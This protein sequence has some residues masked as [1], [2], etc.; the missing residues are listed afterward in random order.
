MFRTTTAEE[1]EAQEVDRNFKAKYEVDDE[2]KEKEEEKE[3][4]IP[5]VAVTT[6]EQQIVDSHSAEESQIRSRRSP[7]IHRCVSRLVRGRGG[8]SSWIVVGG[9]L[10]TGWYYNTRNVQGF[11]SLPSINDNIDP[12]SSSSSSN[13]KMIASSQKQVVGVV[14]KRSNT[15]IIM[16]E[17]KHNHNVTNLDITTVDN[18]L[19]LSLSHYE[20]GY[21][22]CFIPSK[23]NQDIGYL[24]VLR[25][26]KKRTDPFITAM[27]RGW[28]LAQWIDEQ[29]GVLPNGLHRH[30]YV[31]APFIIQLNET[32]LTE[33]HKIHE[34]SKDMTDKNREKLLAMDVSVQKVK[35]IEIDDFLFYKCRGSAN[36]KFNQKKEEYIN[37]VIKMGNG[38]D[39][40]KKL[41]E[42]YH[43]LQTIFKL[44]PII[45]PDFHAL[46]DTKG[47]MYFTDLD[48]DNKKG[49]NQKQANKCL[50]GID[51][52]IDKTKRILSK[53]KEELP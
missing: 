1:E 37:N 26:R 45:V 20:C 2:M 22:K 29:F 14:E 12:S 48:H 53:S 27:I 9:V 24:L 35:K 18:D 19:D 51:G 16:E 43:T 4:L 46:F 38:I 3:N 36:E 21:I 6:E 47:N 25:S 30:F 42:G 34:Q 13:S 52:L 41:E 39:F 40:Y 28:H 32:V 33:L 10:L 17:T 15:T 50:E 31:D 44:K 8:L 49:S 11:F 7:H 23:S 5:E